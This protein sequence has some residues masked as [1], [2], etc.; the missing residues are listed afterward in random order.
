MSRAWYLRVPRRD[1]RPKRQRIPDF[2]DLIRQLSRGVL[3][4][5]K[6]NRGQSPGSAK[7]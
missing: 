4:E 5:K 7:G 2:L 6:P 1:S 3:E